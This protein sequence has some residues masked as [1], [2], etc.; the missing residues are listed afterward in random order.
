LKLGAYVATQGKG[1]KDRY[2]MPI[3][4]SAIY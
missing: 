1:G 3:F 4:N 2:V